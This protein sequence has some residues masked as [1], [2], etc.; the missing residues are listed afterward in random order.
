MEE[1]GP[2]QK[3]LQEVMARCDVLC[4]PK[5][6]KLFKGAKDGAM[7]VRHLSNKN[8]TKLGLEGRFIIH[9]RLFAQKY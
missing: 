5:P 9:N 6:P 3:T 1:Q 7:K 2:S 4:T 8:I